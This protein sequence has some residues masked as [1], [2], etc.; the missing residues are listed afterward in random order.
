MLR[1]WMVVLATLSLV[2]CAARAARADATTLKV[3]TLAPGDSP[4]GQV[5]KVWAKAVDEKSN[6]SIALQWFWNGTQGDENQMVGKIRTGQLDG[7]AITAVGLGQ[8]YKH[9][10]VFQMPGVFSTWQKLDSARNQ[11]KG[12][13]EPEFSNAGFTVLGWG[14]VGA[15]KMMSNGFEVRRPADLAGKG[16]YYLAGDPIGPTLFSL[17]PGCTPKQV[18]VPEILPDLTNGSINVITAP[19]LAAEQLQ[20][21]SRITHINTMTTGFGVGA[22]IVSS[23]RMNGLDQKLK[24]VLKETGEVAGKA[25]TD[26]IRNLDAQAFARLK[27]S[28]SAYEPNDAEKAEWVK[29]FADTR[30]RLRGAT[31]DPAIFDEVLRLAQ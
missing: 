9:V 5:F 29:L 6:H 28:K 22:I 25:L 3:G 31:F 19:A 14:D 8:I 11:M 1:R 21:A 10:L 16:T 24:Q 26:R 4:W 13:L 17:I 30:A 2:L 12:K 27:S 20:W 15:A 18:T 7:A 23:S